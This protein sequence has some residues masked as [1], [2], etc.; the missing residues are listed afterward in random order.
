[1]RRMWLALLAVPALGALIPMLPSAGTPMVRD[2]PLVDV[3]TVDRAPRMLV[4]NTFHVTEGIDVDV[5][6][7][8][9][10]QGVEITETVI[11]PGVT[12][13]ASGAMHGAPKRPGTYT[14]LV[15]L[16][17]DSGCVRERVALVVHRNIP[18]QPGTLTF[19]G[20]VGVPFDSQI[21][22]VG[23][24]EVPPAF[25]VRDTSALPKNVTIGPDGHVGG[26]PVRAGLSEVP[27]R[28]CLAGNCGGVI[29]TL[30]VV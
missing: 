20:R 27:V 18:W 6:L 8:P 30:I 29:V 13:D 21:T 22:V 1:M 24:P 12:L 2:T 14:K 17:Q 28:V 25:T 19:P 10:E 16:C 23:G 5:R 11:A 15:K 7:M 3:A 9:V 4:E 26:V